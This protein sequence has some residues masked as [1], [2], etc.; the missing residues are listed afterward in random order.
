MER[1]A[2]KATDHR[3]EKSLTQL[4]DLTLLIF[5]FSQAVLTKR[6]WIK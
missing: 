2:W 5:H 3:V 4:R 1:E 6:Q